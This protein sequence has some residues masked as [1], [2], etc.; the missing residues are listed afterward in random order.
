MRSR[1]LNFRL[2]L[3]KNDLAPKGKLAF[4]TWYLLGLDLLLLAVEKLVGLFRPPYSEYLSGWLGFLSTVVVLLVCVLAARWISS[5]LLWRLRNRLIVTYI[6]IG[7]I[8]LI[9]F[10]LR[11]YEDRELRRAGELLKKALLVVRPAIVLARKEG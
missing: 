4:L 1:L 3:E 10:A 11:F 5:R 9:L 6:F 7:V 8:P 2:W